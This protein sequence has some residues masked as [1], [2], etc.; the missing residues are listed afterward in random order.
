MNDVGAD[1]SSAWMAGRTASVLSLIGV[2]LLLAGTDAMAD[3]SHP[4]EH[5]PGRAV[6]ELGPA[7]SDH[8]PRHGGWFFM[9]P[10]GWHHLEG[11]LPRPDR[12]H[13]Y[14]YD[15]HTR[16]IPATPFLPDARA[17]VQR[18]DAS[19]K[20]VGD[21]V[22]IRLRP[23]EDGTRLEA[24]IPAGATLP[25]KVELSLKFDPARREAFFNFDFPVPS[26]VPAGETHS[27]R[28]P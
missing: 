19:G 12:F 17:W 1:G 2:L 3:A 7:H 14:L 20:E 5:P 26:L 6:P 15:D 25:F 27:L 28:K 9:A 23:A 4:P 16:P 8:R 13:L 10:D 21:R 24:P 22:E 18:Y 11:A